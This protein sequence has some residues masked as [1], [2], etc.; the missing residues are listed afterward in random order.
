[1]AFFGLVLG[2]DAGASEV[3][4]ESITSTTLASSPSDCNF[5]LP[6]SGKET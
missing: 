4:R 1:M 3:L 6:F 2:S 5:Y